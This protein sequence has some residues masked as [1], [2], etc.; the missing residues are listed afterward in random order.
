MSL[1]PDRPCVRCGRPQTPAFRPFCSAGCKDR[2]LLDW[3]DERHVVPGE[4]V[5]DN[6]GGDA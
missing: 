3:L 5:L 6:D 1:P 4:V 2:D